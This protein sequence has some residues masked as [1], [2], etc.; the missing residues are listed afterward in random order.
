MIE[1]GLNTTPWEHKDGVYKEVRTAIETLWKTHGDGKWKSKIMINDRI[2]DSI[3]Q[4]VHHP[5]EEYSILA[6]AELEMA[7][8]ISDACAAQSADSASLPAATSATSTLSLKPRTELRPS[9]ADRDMIKPRLVILS[10]VMML[11]FM[12]GP[13]PRA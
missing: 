2:A 6:T 10:G 4:Q 3:F 7:T 5:P 8:Y 12:D 13:R 1:P 9:T 11:D